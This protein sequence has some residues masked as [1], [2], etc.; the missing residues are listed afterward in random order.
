MRDARSLSNDKDIVNAVSILTRCTR[1]E[2]RDALALT[3]TQAQD[4]VTTDRYGQ[5]RENTFR[6]WYNQYSIPKK[7]GKFRTIREPAPVLKAVQS[8]IKDIILPKVPIHTSATAGEPWSSYIVNA[9]MHARNHPRFLINMDIKDAYPSVTTAHVR[10]HLTR[11]LQQVLDISFP[12]YS[13]SQ[14]QH[15]ID[16]LTL[17]VVHDNQLPQ[18][19]STSM[20]LLNI[21][22]SDLD[23]AIQKLLHSNKQALYSLVSSRYVDDISVSFKEFEDMNSVWKTRRSILQE[24]QNIVSDS[25]WESTDDV[26]E[27]FRRL[28]ISIQELEELSFV[29]TNSKQR[30]HIIQLIDA[31]QKYLA[32]ILAF[33]E[34]NSHDSLREEIVSC[35]ERMKKFRQELETMKLSD[36]VWAL[37]Q[38]ISSVVSQQ[39]WKVNDKKTKIYTPTSS[40]Q[41][42]V[43]G[44]TFDK[45]WK[46]GIPARK[47]ISIEGFVKNALYTPDRL[48]EKYRGNERLI[49]EA[50]IGMRNYVIQV[51]WWLNRDLSRLFSRA[52]D[53]YYPNGL[54][55]REYELWY[56]Y[57][58][59]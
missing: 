27:Q 48:H 36:Y 46:L 1:D 2:I 30:S 40:E 42:E 58:W 32:N 18:G 55:G 31:I 16:M 37:Q 14:K 50:I 13:S 12:H 34:N 5:E 52:Q 19:S 54:K 49:A 3:R 24:L 45:T 15:I 53:M 41:K 21:V 8:G 29:I 10:E 20:K 26:L 4:I 43:T 7:D 28:N 6:Y 51:R 25:A 11:W 38:R 22:L 39:W 23:V 59:E 56:N 17:L 9:K 33:V 35:Q 44:V 47:V 57:N